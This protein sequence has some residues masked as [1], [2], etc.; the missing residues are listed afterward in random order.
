MTTLLLI[1]HAVNDYVKTG[2]LA[3]R[4]P[5]VHLNEEGQAQAQRWGRGWPTNC[6]ARSTPVPGAYTETA[7]A[8]SRLIT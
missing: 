3:G 1:R 5:G 6:C 4:T 8:R 2:K 7:H